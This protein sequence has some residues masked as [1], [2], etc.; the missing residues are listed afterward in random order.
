MPSIQCTHSTGPVLNKC[1]VL[2]KSFSSSANHSK[3]L[4]N[5]VSRVPVISSWFAQCQLWLTMASVTLLF[6]VPARHSTAHRLVPF[7]QQ[8]T[9]YAVDVSFLACAKLSLW[10][11]ITDRPSGQGIRLTVNH[12][13]VPRLRIRGVWLSYVKGHVQLQFPLVSLW[14]RHMLTVLLTMQ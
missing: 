11:D 2:L 10:Q 8:V 9:A 6:A 4:A 5:C 13:V 12:H 14:N 7:S 3:R 1:N